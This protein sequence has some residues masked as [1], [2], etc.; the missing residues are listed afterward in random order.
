MIL[1]TLRGMS[2]DIAHSARLAENASVIGD[3]RLE[4]FVTVWYGAVLRGGRR[5]PSGWAAGPTSRTTAS[6]TA[7]WASP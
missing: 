4:A 2:P 3:V 5:P 7:N 6:S 1:R